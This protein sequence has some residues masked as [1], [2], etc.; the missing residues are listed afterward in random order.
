M[1]STD[2]K[3]AP[4][5]L[6]L[7][8]L[9]AVV[10]LHVLAAM[11]LVTMTPSTPVIKEQDIPPI[12]IQMVNLPIATLKPEL[13]EQ[14]ITVEPVP[15][16]PTKPVIDKKPI[17]KPIP[18]NEPKKSEEKR[19]EKPALP[20]EP[21][22]TPEAKPITKELPP[23]S[24]THIEDIKIE[25]AEIATTEPEPVITLQPKHIIEDKVVTETRVEKE[26]RP[27][28]DNSAAQTLAEQQRQIEVIK[29]A[30]R[31]AEQ[32]AIRDTQ[33]AA[34][35]AAQENVQA[36]KRAA[37]DQE[38]KA[39]ADAK[40]KARVETEAREKTV[41]R[42]K[43]KADVEAKTKAEAASNTPM[44]F[45]AS[46][47]NWSSKPNFSFPDRASRSASSGDT[48]N[49]VLL[50]RVNKQGGID[51]VSLAQSSG[52]AILDRE[53]L[54]QVRSGKFRPFMNNGVP[55]VGNVTLPVSYAVP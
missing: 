2:F 17:N 18:K 20:P 41:A 54:R 52:N 25:K 27:I 5:N 47:A 19:V 50:L 23:E 14:E 39:K 28:I 24:A 33:Q 22:I 21:K 35:K 40:A 10:G 1:G 4:R 45:S 42:E 51:S 55:V 29:Q 44:N 8:A 26:D 53:A 38:A 34:E 15:V 48:F 37:A 13:I 43:S 11:A 9:S 36:A 16:E 6:T 3:T 49:L 12:E 7:I 32:A 30:K 31:A 46:N